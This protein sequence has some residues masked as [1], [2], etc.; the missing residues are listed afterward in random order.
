MIYSLT[1]T[2]LA[3]LVL[4][5][6][7]RSHIDL[8]QNIARWFADVPAACWI[9]IRQLLTHTS[10][11]PDY[12]TL[13]EYHQAVRSSPGNPW[14]E[15]ELLERSL[16]QGLQFEPGAKSSYSN[17]GYLL[18]RCIIESISGK[19]FADVVQKNFSSP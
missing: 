8:D 4:K 10:G 2:I 1:K 15:A 3:T 19:S 5:L 18:L 13:R 14:S 17:I 11:L 6:V 7:E 12:G 9:T 16:V